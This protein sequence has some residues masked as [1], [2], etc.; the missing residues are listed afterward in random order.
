MPFEAP[1][2]SDATASHLLCTSLQFRSTDAA[3]QAA[4][5]DA[6]VNLITYV[7]RTSDTDEP[8]PTLPQRELTVGV[9]DGEY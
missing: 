3:T 5:I 8:L 9:D 4:I 6:F 1:E 2:L 7:D